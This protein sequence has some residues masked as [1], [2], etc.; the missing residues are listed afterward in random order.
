MTVNVAR[1]DPTATV[2]TAGH[3]RARGSTS[4]TTVVVTYADADNGIDTTSF[5][6]ADITVS[7]GATVTSYSANG[8]VVTYTIKAPSSTWSASTQ[9]TYTIK[10][11]ANQVKD[12]AGNYVTAN[13]NLAT[14]KVD[15]VVPTA[16]V[17]TA[18]SAVLASNAS[19]TTTTV[20][21]TYADS[22]LGLDTSTFGIGDITVSNG[23]TVTG[24]WP[25][26]AW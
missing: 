21:V 3:D 9:G 1:P 17:P 14:F 5:G 26:A 18:P 24:C 4:T 2:T 16:S 15:T 13:D 12:L 25:A 6:T 23:A 19:Q 10:L 22:G 8:N 7:N 11:A 20:S